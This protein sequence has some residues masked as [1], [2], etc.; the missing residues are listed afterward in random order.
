MSR[1]P[2]CRRIGGVSWGRGVPSG[3]PFPRRQRK[4]SRRAKASGTLDWSRGE[5][6]ACVGGDF[7]V[8]VV[9]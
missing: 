3:T 4:E 8:A 9:A 7:G 2:W 6:C 5:I 1:E